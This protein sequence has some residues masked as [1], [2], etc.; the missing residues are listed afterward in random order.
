MLRADLA[1][2]IPINTHYGLR[3]ATNTFCRQSQRPVHNHS[4]PDPILRL[5]KEYENSLSGLGSPVFRYQGLGFFTALGTRGLEPAE[6]LEL[7]APGLQ[8]GQIMKI[9]E[10]AG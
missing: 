10:V 9:Q 2:W 3:A 8:I 1:H 5:Q 7:T 4:A 6:E